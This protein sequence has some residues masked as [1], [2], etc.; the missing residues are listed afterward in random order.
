MKLSMAAERAIHSPFRWGLLVLAVVAGGSAVLA[1]DP[2]WLSGI[3]WPRPKVVDPGPPGGV[4]ADAIVLFDGKGLSRHWT[5]GEKWKVADGAGTCGGN[6]TTTRPFGD[7][8]LHVEWAAPANPDPKRVSQD[9]GNSG[10][11]LMGCYEVQILDSYNNE[12]YFDGQAAAI[13]KQRPPLVNACRPPGEW[14][15]YDI[16]FRGPRFDAGGKLLRPAFITLLHNGVV[17]Q[18]NFELLGQT[19]YRKPPQYNPHPL[20]A[21]LS[22]Q[23][24]GHPVKFRNIWIRD[25]EDDREDL[26]KPLR[27]RLR[28]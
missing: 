24:H 16:L 2:P 12:T 20:K 22:I 7:C 15:T 5:G 10:L 1:L 13:Y 26:L 21:P 9:R 8:Q 18:N 4:P 27:D 19:A 25:L 28:K 6:L 17:V 3:V 14:Q 23:H 11:K